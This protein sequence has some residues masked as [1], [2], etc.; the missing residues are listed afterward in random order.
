MAQIKKAYS[1]GSKPNEIVSVKDFGAEWDGVTDDSAAVQEFVDYCGANN[2]MG[3]FPPGTGVFSNIVISTT[4]QGL[5]LK[6]AGKQRTSVGTGC[7][8]L[9]NNASTAMFQVAGTGTHTGLSLTNF[10]YRQSSVS[11]GPL[12]STPNSMSEANIGDLDWILVNP[13]TN[14][15]NI[16]AVSISNCKFEDHYG[17]LAASATV[18]PYYIQSQPPGSYFNNTFS[19][20]FINSNDTTTAPVIR[21]RDSSGGSTNA[22]NLFDDLVFEF[23]ANGGAIHASS[24]RNSQF[25][26]IFADD[27]TSNGA[28]IIHLDKDVTAGSRESAYNTFDTC[29]VEDGDATWK[30]LHIES[31]GPGTHT[32]LRNSSFGFVDI[33]GPPYLNLESDVS[34]E[35][36]AQPPMKMFSGVLTVPENGD[37]AFQEGMSVPEIQ[38]GKTG[39]LAAG[40]NEVVV[41]PHTFSNTPTVVCSHTGAT[42]KGGP[43]QSHTP[44]TTGVTIV[45]HGT[46]NTEITWIASSSH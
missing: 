18:S 20:W 25:T 9:K 28:Y 1:V 2:C 21:I 35:L 30:D 33:E 32:V 10:S 4:Y 7:T 5:S 27:S 41:F 40:A 43:A 12:F 17:T 37:I 36:S 23:C 38:T 16:T 22:C 24:I 15:I 42:D 34:N 39:V 11:D 29:F 14:L 13:A 8:I 26:N 6:G 19:G 46:S 45:N 3:I 44:S 31:A